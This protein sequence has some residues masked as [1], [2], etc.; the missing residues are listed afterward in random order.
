M[1][2]TEENN[3]NYITWVENLSR[4]A[5]AILIHPFLPLK[6]Y[7]FNYSCLFSKQLYCFVKSSH[8]SISAHHT[9]ICGLSKQNPTYLN[10]IK[11]FLEKIPN[12]IKQNAPNNKIH[13]DSIGLVDNLESYIVHAYT[14]LRDYAQKPR[15]NCS[16]IAG[17]LAL[18]SCILTYYLIKD[19]RYVY[20]YAITYRSNSKS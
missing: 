2:L 7:G 12:Y 20:H 11:L 1:I 16:L 18:C 9:R 19:I 3:T 5:I 17:Q 8:T 6:E 10:H 13:T 14:R 4:G 15:P